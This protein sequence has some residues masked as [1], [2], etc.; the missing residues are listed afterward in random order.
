MR[1][2]ADQHRQHDGLPGTARTPDQRLQDSPFAC[3]QHSHKTRPRQIEQR[4]HQD[5][6][7]QAERDAADRARVGYPLNFAGVGT[8]G[9]PTNGFDS[10]QSNWSYGAGIALPFGS[11]IDLFGESR[12]RMSQYVLP[13]AQDAPSPSNEFRVGITFHVGGVNSRSR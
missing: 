1:P 3:R 11:V 13:T 5:P 6:R 4:R 9:G 8:S 2:N 10:R 12:W 7:G